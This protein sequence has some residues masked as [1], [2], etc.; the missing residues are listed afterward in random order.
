MSDRTPEQRK[1]LWELRRRSK[2][3]MTD[4]LRAME[5]NE[6]DIEKALKWL[7]T[8]ADP[9]WKLP[10]TPIPPQEIHKLG[11]LMWNDTKVHVVDAPSSLPDS[12]ILPQIV[13]TIPVRK[14]V[15]VPPQSDDP[16]GFRL[17]FTCTEL[18][19]ATVFSK[20]FLD[21][22]NGPP[23][24]Y[25]RLYWW[26]YDRKHGFSVWWCDTFHQNSYKEEV[27]AETGRVI[28]KKCP[29]CNKYIWREM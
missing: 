6:W 12:N 2:G 16:D 10:K 7:D 20:R 14:D 1:L 13:A 28:G 23:V 27:K 18:I 26:W 11:D 19:G 9:R 17:G 15:D 22:L 29:K 4:A 24:W 3:S 8:N 25:K 21:Y 5:A